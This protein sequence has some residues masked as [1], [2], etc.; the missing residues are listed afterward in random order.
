MTVLLLDLE[1]LA[2]LPEL[3]QALLR[4]LRSHAV[5]CGQELPHQ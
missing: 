3:D 5:D 4:K 1:A 2:H